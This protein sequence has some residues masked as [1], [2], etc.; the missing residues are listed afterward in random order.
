MT[1][2]TWN[3][4]PKKKCSRSW[5]SCMVCNKKGL[6]EV[7][8][9]VESFW[10]WLG[11]MRNDLLWIAWIQI[12]SRPFFWVIVFPLKAERCYCAV[13][14]YVIYSFVVW[15]IQQSLSLGRISFL[16]YFDSSQLRATTDS[17]YSMTS[18]VTLALALAK[19]FSSRSVVH[20]TIVPK[21]LL[22]LLLLLLPWVVFVVELVVITKICKTVFSK[23]GSSNTTTWRF[24]L[25]SK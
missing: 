20:W 25:W 12:Q 22:L 9:H 16:Q 18:K 17:L 8:K 2:R 14:L 7:W 4:N 10:N 21:K 5:R 6:K 13:L 3:L 11:R 23:A 1:I 15:Q 19:Q 24:F